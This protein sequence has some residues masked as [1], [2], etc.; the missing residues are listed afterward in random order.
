[1]FRTDPFE[2]GAGYY[3]T[4]AFSG[5]YMLTF[6]FLLAYP[7]GSLPGFSGKSEGVK[8]NQLPPGK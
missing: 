1:M 6:E 3:R 5:G 4:R 2:I 8:W 7:P